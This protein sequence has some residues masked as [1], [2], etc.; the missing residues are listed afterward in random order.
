MLGDMAKTIKLTIE[1]SKMGTDKIIIMYEPV[2]NKTLQH[3]LCLKTKMKTGNKFIDH[4][5]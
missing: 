3:I 2:I 5:F 1:E 4:I